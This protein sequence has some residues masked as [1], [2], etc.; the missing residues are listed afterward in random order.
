VKNILKIYS[1][2]PLL[3]TSK[4]KTIYWFF[5]LLNENIHLS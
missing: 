1:V 4:I 3:L 2:T 5:E